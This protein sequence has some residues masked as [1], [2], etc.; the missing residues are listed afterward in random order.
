MDRVLGNFILALRSSGVRISV[1]ETL[2]AMQVA[3]LVGYSDR[4]LLKTS[5][6]SSLAKSLP[7]KELFEHCFE[8]YF[9]TDIAVDHAPDR[10]NSPE[11]ADTEVPLLAQ[12]ILSGNMPGLAIAMGEAGN[13]VDMTGMQ[14]FTQKGLYIRRIQQRMGMDALGDYIRALQGQGGGE[15][16]RTAERLEEGRSDLAESVRN[17][18]ERQ[19]DL[20]SGSASGEMLERYLRNMRLSNLEQTHYHQMQAIIQRIVKQLRDLHSRRKKGAKRGQLDFKKT[21]RNNISHQGLLFDRRWKMKKLDRPKVMVICDVSRSVSTIVR[22]FLLILYSMN[23]LVDKILTFI[24]CSNLVEVTDIFEKYALEEALVRLQTG[25][26][27]DIWMGRTDY[28]QSLRDFWS[29]WGRDV[30]KKTTVIILGDARSNYGEPEV[31]ILKK[32]QERCKQLIWLNP[33]TPSLWGSGDSEMR[34]Y[35]P[36]CHM[37]REC[38]TLNHLEKVMHALL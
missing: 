2:D 30:T 16:V 25:A 14:Y 7:E 10:E 3:Q 37:A 8:R 29:G 23:E 24:L 27:L 6:G 34:R 32:I 20:Y 36:F 4:Q 18:V 12:L 19:F 5:L 22:F 9:T 33:E 17:F 26:G 28:G 38:S 13:A 21:L 1:S 15:A 11:G 35:L 31:E